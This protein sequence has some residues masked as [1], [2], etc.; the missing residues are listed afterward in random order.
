MIKKK[1]IK[2]KIIM[3]NRKLKKKLLRILKR[4]QIMMRWMKKSFWLRQ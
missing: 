4:N 3:R 2:K 1:K